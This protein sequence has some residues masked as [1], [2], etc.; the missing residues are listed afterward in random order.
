MSS[1]T[2]VNVLEAVLLPVAAAAMGIFVKWA[3]NRV[4]DRGWKREYASLGFEWMLAAFLFVLAFSFKAGVDQLDARRETEVSA[5]QLISLGDP[6]LTPRL[7]DPDLGSVRLFCDR[8]AMSNL[9]APRLQQADMNHFLHASLTSIK[10]SR[11]RLD[12]AG[13]QRFVG[14]QERQEQLNN[15]RTLTLAFAVVVLL[16]TWVVSIVVQ[17]WGYEKSSVRRGSSRTTERLRVW[18]GILLPDAVGLL[19]LLMTLFVVPR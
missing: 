18:R 11:Q 1:S 14:S 6:S 5:I 15:S 7:E 12:V 3:T 17:E 4:G 10:N 16:T 2:T 13:C 9:N 8:V 19:F